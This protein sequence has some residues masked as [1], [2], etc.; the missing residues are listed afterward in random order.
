[1]VAGNLEVNRGSRPRPG[2]Q[3][4]QLHAAQRSFAA[5]LSLAEVALKHFNQ[6]ATVS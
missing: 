5:R 4:V 3:G 2:A 6:I 1:V